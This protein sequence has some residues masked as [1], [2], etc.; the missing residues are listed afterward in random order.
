MSL[1]DSARKEGVNQPRKTRGE[2]RKQ[3]GGHGVR[4]YSLI[5]K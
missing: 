4:P 2:Q 3:E 1:N 5:A